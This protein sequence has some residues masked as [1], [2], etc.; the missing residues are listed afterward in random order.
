VGIYSHHR[1]L[2][3]DVDADGEQGLVG[4]LSRVTGKS[5]QMDDLLPD[6]LEKGVESSLRASEHD[7]PVG[8]P[9]AAVVLAETRPSSRT[10]FTDLDSFYADPEEESEEESEECGESES[11]SED[12]D[13]SGKEDDVIHD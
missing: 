5:M 7:V 3:I 1:R 12:A 6:W 11:D 10:E 13:G 4:S 8:V 2:L 9:S